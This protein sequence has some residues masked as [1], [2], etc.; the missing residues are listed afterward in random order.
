MATE[1]QNGLLS[2]AHFCG[3]KD[4][5]RGGSG[6]YNALHVSMGEKT[7][8]GDMN[9]PQPTFFH[10]VAFFPSGSAAR[11]RR[12]RARALA[13]HLRFQLSE[14]RALT[15]RI[16][17]YFST[18]GRRIVSAI[19]DYKEPGPDLI[20]AVV[21]SIEDSQPLL[22]KTLEAHYRTI[23]E[24]VGK[25]VFKAVAS[26]RRAL[27]DAVG[28]VKACRYTNPDYLKDTAGVFDIAMQD[29]IRHNGLDKARKIN[30]VTKQRIRN[31]LMQG[32]RDGKGTSDL[33]R[34]I[35]EYIEPLKNFDQRTRSFVIAR[36]E[37]HTASNAA[38]EEAMADTK[39]P[40]TREWAQTSGARGRD[41]HAEANGQRRQQEEP[42]DVGGEKLMFPGDPAGSPGN[43][44]NCMCVLLYFPAEEDVTQDSGTE[45]VVEDTFNGRRFSPDDSQGSIKKWGDSVS[46]EW[47]KSLSPSEVGA[48]HEYTGSGYISINGV[49][50]HS[51]RK[52]PISINMAE[53]IVDQLDVATGI[54][55]QG[56]ETL[57]R[58]LN[59]YV[60]KVTPLER[61]MAKAALPEDVV[62]FR[63]GSPKLFGRK[64]L[65]GINKSLVGKTF[66]DDG[67]ISASLSEK[68]ATGF[69]KFRRVLV[70]IEAPK[71]TKAGILTHRG[72]AIHPSEVEVLL[73]KGTRFRVTK[74]EDTS[75]T[76]FGGRSVKVKKVTVRVVG[77]KPDVKSLEGAFKDLES[78]IADKLGY[79]A[80]S[81]NKA[82]SSVNKRRENFYFA[83]E[84]GFGITWEK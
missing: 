82:A 50:R 78:E 39:I 10:A 64:D 55:V 22:E 13:A 30:G 53:D 42:F 71:G 12:K 68:V 83:W 57:K 46:S 75:T 16:N 84:D 58:A 49:L 21:D 15:L 41:I 3:K 79:K 62:L 1:T 32:I 72:V 31:L 29:W 17:Q 66:N 56:K 77:V 43:V 80:T 33:A 14:E 81:I 18:Q 34:S 20:Q 35:R 5:R 76:I 19:N 69:S 60:E 28:F 7:E 45:E 73:T 51:T 44:V 9:T 61:G 65:K 38:T 11:N 27:T 40:M 48:F 63:G 25:D 26:N 59:K 70:E 74:V 23:W 36:T 6:G 52:G 54:Y 67:F 24:A 37:T 2:G 47:R 4:D 8:L